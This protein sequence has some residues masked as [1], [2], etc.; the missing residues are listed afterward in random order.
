[1]I[2]KNKVAILHTSFSVLGGAERVI[3]NLARQLQAK[4]YF[5][6]LFGISFSHPEVKTFL[7]HH[8]IPF[9]AFAFNQVLNLSYH[10]RALAWLIK[11]YFTDYDILNV[12]N[13]PS[14][15]WA[16]YARQFSRRPFPKII[17][18]CHEPPRHLYPLLSHSFAMQDPALRKHIQASYKW[19]PNPKQIQ[20]DQAAVKAIDKIL[21]NSQYTA[22]LISKIY[23]RE[24]E[25]VHFGSDLPS[26]PETTFSAHP[27]EETFLVHPSGETFLAHPLP[28]FSQNNPYL[29]FV[30]RIDWAKNLK[31]LLQAYYLVA[32][33]IKLNLVLCGAG[34]KTA[35]I[36]SL[37]SA[38]NLGDRVKLISNATDA[39]LSKLYQN[40][41][42]VVYVPLDEPLGLIPIEAAGY[43][44]AS[45]VSSHGG[46]AEIIQDG[47]SGLTAN[48]LSPA[49]IAE[50]MLLLANPKIA[51]KMGQAAYQTIPEKYSYAGF[52]HQFATIAQSL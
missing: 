3:L 11:K 18:L 12:H 46:P 25:I 14:Y 29:L 7:H 24:V 16:V 49:D 21:A 40:A 48:A 51:Q 45:L 32:N 1:M 9:T 31:T 30:G 2:K 5:V 33:Q 26:T 27:S 47:I 50:K 20:I 52:A 19:P 37:I 15:I 10:F 36:K 34:P 8:K 6:K 13:Y 4:G 39:E 17:W 44:K 43:G 42:F 28:T 22:M 41:A 23:S 38:L 35:E